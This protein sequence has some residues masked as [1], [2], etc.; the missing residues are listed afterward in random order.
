MSAHEHHHDTDGHDHSMSIYQFFGNI[1]GYPLD[2]TL[3]F[4]VGDP[5]FWAGLKEKL[6]NERTHEALE[7]IE[8]AVEQIASIPEDRR[9]MALDAEFAQTFL[10]PDSPMPP[11]ESDYGLPGDEVQAVAAEL[12][13]LMSIQRFLPDD[14]IANELFV[15]A[16]LDYGT[17]PTAEQLQTLADFF[18]R[19]PMA[20]LRRMLDHAPGDAPDTGFYRAIVELTL[21][22]M[23]WD[24]DA[25]EAE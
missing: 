25:H 8:A 20:L 12:G 15:L 6:D 17:L 21:A 14:H 2:E 18:E 7:H 19:H 1:L 16:P 10:L 11:L 5:T 3:L 23:Q 4:N 22:W 9:K 13:A 24:L